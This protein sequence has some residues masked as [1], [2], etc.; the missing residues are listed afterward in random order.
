V[1]I[2]D[3]AAWR[4]RHLNYVFASG[5]HFEEINAVDTKDAML[6]PVTQT[7]MRKFKISATTPRNNVDNS[8]A[9]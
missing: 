1:L 5:V 4:V 6:C 2:E 8:S 9:Y 7:I 3:Y